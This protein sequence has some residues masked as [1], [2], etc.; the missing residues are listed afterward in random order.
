MVMMVLVVMVM[1]VMSVMRDEFDALIWSSPSLAQTFL[2][3]APLFVAPWCFAA[4][5]HWYSFTHGVIFHTG[6]FSHWCFFTL[7][8]FCTLVVNCS[9]HCT[10]HFTLCTA[11]LCFATW[12]ANLHWC[13]FAQCTKLPG[14]QTALRGTV[15]CNLVFIG[16]SCIAMSCGI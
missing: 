7:V 10:M 9:A 16:A 4:N 2:H 15:Q 14:V 6:V 13:S 5:L 1:M 11:A 3:G 8:L 12:C